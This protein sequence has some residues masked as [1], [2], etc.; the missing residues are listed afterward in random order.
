MQEGRI[1]YVDK[2]CDEAKDDPKHLPALVQRTLLGY[3]K[4]LPELLEFLILLVE[5][6][7]VVL[8]LCGFRS[9]RK[10]GVTDFFAES[11]GAR[12]MQG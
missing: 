5:L 11:E 9:I 1:V 4:F 6:L 10:D 12:L 2:S 8:D 7:L 3:G